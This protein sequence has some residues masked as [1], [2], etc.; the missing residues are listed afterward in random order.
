MQMMQVAICLE[1]GDVWH[2]MRGWFA[3]CKHMRDEE[4]E[5]EKYV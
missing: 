1:T 2:P 4:N 3:D 5:E